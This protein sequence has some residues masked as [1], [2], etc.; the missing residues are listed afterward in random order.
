MQMMFQYGD[1]KDR[2]SVFK[3]IPD[4]ACDLATIH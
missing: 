2:L 4:C 3:S 1:K